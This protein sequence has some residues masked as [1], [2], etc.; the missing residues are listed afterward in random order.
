LY[1]NDALTPLTSTLSLHDALPIYRPDEPDRGEYHEDDDEVLPARPRGVDR[2]H[3]DDDGD[4]P[5]DGDDPVQGGWSPFS[6]N[7]RGERR[8]GEEHPANHHHDWAHGSS[9]SRISSNT[10]R[11][12]SATCWGPS[13]LRIRSSPRG[14][15][16]AAAS[17][18]AE[19][20]AY[21]I[22]RSCSNPVALASSIP[23]EISASNT[24]T[25]TRPVS[26]CASTTTDPGTSD[27]NWA[28]IVS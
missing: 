3:R 8:G 12:S 23:P 11:S 1:S 17:A 10:A 18:A 24:C 28:V 16:P 27:V 6:A 5:V 22:R 7:E 9:P 20:S 2:Q 25:Y 21:M 26:R 4:E 13:S 14:G 15:Y 19:A